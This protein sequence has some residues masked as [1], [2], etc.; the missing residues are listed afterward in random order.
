MKD[1]YDA[2]VV[3]ARCAG[4]PT[5][6]LLARAGHRVLLVDRARFPSNTMS[7]HFIHPH[8]IAR[9]ARWG[10]LDEVLA[11]GCPPISRW[12]FDFGFASFAGS[13]PPVDGVAEALA[14][15]RTVLDQILF[16]AAAGAGAEV[17]EAFT[18]EEL[19]TDGDRITGVRGHAADGRT[20]TERARVVVGADGMRSR[21]ARWVGAREYNAQPSLTCAY[22][23]YWAGVPMEGVEVYARDGRVLLAF[24][25]NDDLVLVFMEWPVAAFDDFRADVEGSF[26]RTLDLVPR[27]AARIRNGQRV[28][29]LVG[30]GVLPNFFRQAHGPGWALVGD[31]GYHKDPYLAQGIG[32]AF[33]D[34][35]RIAEALG[36]GL[37]DN[38]PLDLALAAYAA[39]RDAA[40]APGYELNLQ[41]ASLQPPPPELQ[42]VLAALPDNPPEAD[43]FVGA[44]MGTVAVGDFFAPENLA[45]IVTGAERQRAT[46]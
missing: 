26:M 16:D 42:A 33:R 28:E 19:V 25:T 44:L 34:A 14:P 2:I 18:V 5:A 30:T 36:D 13:P 41:L 29:R 24:P 8:G 32:D 12:H 9:M 39:D 10:L 1:R 27:L 43:R 45:R 4:S 21:V 20:V 22:Y 40:A 7:G 3:G 38:R 31:A 11:S 35:E 17:R 46:A 6:M 15:R 37:A 23:G